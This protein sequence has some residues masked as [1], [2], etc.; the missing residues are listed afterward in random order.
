MNAFDLKAHVASNE[1]KNATPKFPEKKKELE[2]L[3]NELNENDNP[4]L[5]LVRPKE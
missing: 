1:F 4:I 2:Q 5:M 3:A